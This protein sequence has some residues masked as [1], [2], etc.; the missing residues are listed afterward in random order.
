LVLQNYSGFGKNPL[1]VSLCSNFEDE[2]N[3]IGRNLQDSR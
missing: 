3:D 2:I 1:I